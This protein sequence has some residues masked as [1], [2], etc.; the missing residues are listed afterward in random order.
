MEAHFAGSLPPKRGGQEVCRFYA[1]GDKCRYGDRCKFLHSGAPSG[2]MPYPNPRAQWNALPFH[3][4][5]GKFET[6]FHGRV[7]E[8][9]TCFAKGCRRDKDK[10]G[11]FCLEYCRQGLTKWSIITKQDTKVALPDRA[12][13]TA[14]FAASIAAQN[15]SN[16]YFAAKES[17]AL[18]EE[19]HED[20]IYHNP[21]ALAAE[22]ERVDP[23]L[24]S[25]MYSSV[26]LGERQSRGHHTC[27]VSI[28]HHQLVNLAGG[29]CLESTHSRRTVLNR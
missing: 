14:V 24:L 15:E 2:G 17:V 23:H 5:R 3:P 13:T 26:M 19:M 12:D 9:R 1:K 22:E 21:Q 25:A 29:H 16:V 28:L 11:A 4:Q 7:V 8:R 10:R 20:A 18:I 6:K 27:M